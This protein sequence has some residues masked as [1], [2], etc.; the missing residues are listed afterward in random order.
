MVRCALDEAAPDESA[1]RGIMH[2]GHGRSNKRQD[3]AL[4]VLSRALF[5]FS[6]VYR[7]FRGAG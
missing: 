4:L 1:R 2:A 3:T 7:D 6:F 5:R